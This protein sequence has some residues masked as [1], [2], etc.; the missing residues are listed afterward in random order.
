M[1]EK[2]V[3]RAIAEYDAGAVKLAAA[4]LRGLKGTNIAKKEQMR[5]IQAYAICLRRRGFGV[6]LHL[7]DGKSVRNQALQMARMRFHAAQRAARSSKKRF[8]IKSIASLPES[9]KLDRTYLVGFTIVP[10]QF[11]KGKWKNFV[12]VS[13]MDGAAMRKR[14]QGVLIARVLRNANDQLMPGS[15]SVMKAAESGISVGGHLGAESAVALEADPNEKKPY[16]RERDVVVLD[17]GPAFIRRT[18]K[19]RKRAKILRCY[20]HK[21][22]DLIRA[23][24]K[25]GVQVLD[26]V[27][28]LTPAFGKHA[29]R[30]ISQLPPSSKLRSVPQ[31][32][33][34][35]A[36]LPKGVHSHSIRTQNDA[37]AFNSMA[38]EVRGEETLLGAMIQTVHLLE[39]RQQVLEEPLEKERARFP[40]GWTS[41][42]A[43][44]VVREAYQIQRAKFAITCKQAVPGGVPGSFHVDASTSAKKMLGIK[45]MWTVRPASMRDDDYLG[46]CTCGGNASSS[47]FCKH[48]AGTIAATDVNWTTFL[49]PWLT[50]KWT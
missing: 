30:K 14:A 19:Q 38:C 2:D 21:K 9:I 27:Q 35:P 12:P 11:M 10:P 3:E 22:T 42:S 48:T 40:Q 47:V 28:A 46:A 6:A 31:A 33:V 18:R 17:G 32:E 7:A 36:L 49:K 50:A 24:D 41:D 37:E 4:V 1:G 39:M 43:P 25:A 15:I 45:R 16:N 5:V 13:S 23:R 44:P 26:D 20:K 29:L 34:A 8:K